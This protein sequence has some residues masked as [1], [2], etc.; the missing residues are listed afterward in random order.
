MGK[1]NTG[2]TAGGKLVAVGGEPLKEGEPFP[3]FK[4]TG[5]D[6]SDVTNEKFQGKVLVVSAVPS[7]DTSVCSTSAR[8]FNEGVAKLSPDVAVL[9]VSRD[10]PF[11]Q[12]RWCGAEGIAKVVTA[13]DYKYRNFGEATGTLWKSDELLTRA[14]FVVGKDGKITYVD[15]IPEISKEPDYAAVEAAVKAAL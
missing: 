12:K 9:T 5:N 6:M 4:L 10:L 3:R 14:V 15:Y 11:A 8:T 2:I 7:L 13:S 1:T